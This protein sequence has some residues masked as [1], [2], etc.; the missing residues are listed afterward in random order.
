MPSLMADHGEEKYDIADQGGE[1]GVFH[2]LE[3]NLPRGGGLL[4]PKISGG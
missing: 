3:D 2:L 1:D 4:C